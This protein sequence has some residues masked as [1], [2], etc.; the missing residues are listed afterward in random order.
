MLDDHLQI[1]EDSIRQARERRS[2]DALASEM[3]E[4]FFECHPE[5]EDR[6]HGFDLKEVRPFK[7][8]KLAD[9]V[10]DVLKYPDYSRTS[11]SEEVFR[12]QIHDIKD[13]EYYFALADTFAATIKS[14][15]GTD[16]SDRHEECWNDALA[17]LKHNVYIAAQEH[18]AQA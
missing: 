5:A 7:F 15:L 12:H 17:G 11:V 9:A 14:T 4:L 2:L 8:C 10:V 3:F 16:W 6:F 18:L 13:K 1:V